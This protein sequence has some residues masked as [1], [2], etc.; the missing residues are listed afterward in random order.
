MTLRQLIES[1]ASALE[2]AGVVFGHGTSNA[3]DEAAW[4]VLW[5][6]GLPLDT[7]LDDG[8]TDPALAITQQQLDQV[9]ALVTRRISSRQPAA[10]LM[11]EAWLQGLSFYCDERAVVP[12]S[13]IAELLV[14]GELDYWLPQGSARLLDL[15]TGGG[16]L[17]VL[18]ALA[19]PQLVVDASD[20]SAQA[21]EVAQINLQQHGLTGRI[22]LL[23]GDGL[24]AADGH[25]DLIL[26]NPPYVNS[27][28][29]QNLPPEYRAE[30][31]LALDGGPD[32]MGFVRG[33][34][35]GALAHLQPA[36]VLVLEVGNERA[37]FE[38]AFPRLQAVWLDTSAGADQV[39]ALTHAALAALN[40]HR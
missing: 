26:C 10:Y 27:A 20:L 7:D 19:W 29:M 34:V 39:C 30:P 22:R 18:A 14:A 25:Y 2:Q 35:R 4:L 23:Q 36:A 21:L 17:A 32:G 11:R 8:G 13:L 6:L 5:Q 38:S 12:R 33:L 15:C 24:A 1:S 9:H 16:S 3:F 40:T 37:N 31:A 28:S